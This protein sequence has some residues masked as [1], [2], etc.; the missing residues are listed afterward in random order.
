MPN[1]PELQ[2]EMDKSLRVEGLICMG[3]AN[4]FFLKL[5]SPHVTE[6]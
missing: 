1:R 3:S 4:S 2:L 6:V 5:I